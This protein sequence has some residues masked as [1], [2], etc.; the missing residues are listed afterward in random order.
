TSVMFIRRHGISIKSPTVPSHQLFPSTFM[1]GI[2]V[3]NVGIPMIRIPP[4]CRS[5]YRGTTLLICYHRK[6]T[7]KLKKLSGFRLNPMCLL[8]TALHHKGGP[9]VWRVP[10]VGFPHSDL[11]GPECGCRSLV[12]DKHCLIKRPHE[13]GGGSVVDWPQAREHAW[14]PGIKESTSES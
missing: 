11:S 6:R 5:L 3:R 4:Q 10:T 14:S 7:G 8:P 9:V 13:R 2:S 1:V 12:A